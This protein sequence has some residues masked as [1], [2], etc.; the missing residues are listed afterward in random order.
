[1]GLVRVPKKISARST[2]HDLSFIHDNQTI[3]SH[4]LNDLL[5]DSN[6]S[7]DT[8]APFQNFGSIP[9]TNDLD[10]ERMIQIYSDQYMLVENAYHIGVERRLQAMNYQHRHRRLLPPSPSLPSAVRRMRSMS[11]TSA[12]DGA[13]DGDDGEGAEIDVEERYQHVSAMAARRKSPMR[14]REEIDCRVRECKVGDIID[15]C[16]YRGTG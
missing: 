2:V 4:H 1:M 3:L 6:P 5:R 11:L 13:V 8:I 15:I 16:G 9:M 14:L 12:Q 10:L 7:Y